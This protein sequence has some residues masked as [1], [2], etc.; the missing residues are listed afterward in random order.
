VGNRLA[1]VVRPVEAWA[2][3]RAEAVGDAVRVGEDAAVG[4]FSVLAI[5]VSKAGL[6]NVEVTA[7]TAVLPV[8]E[9]T[10]RLLSCRIS[11]LVPAVVTLSRLPE[12]TPW[13]VKTWKV[14]SDV[15]LNPSRL[16]STNCPP[17]CRLPVADTRSNEA[18]S[19]PASW[20]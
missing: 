2:V 14:W 3:L 17:N 16:L 13:L 11:R 5:S 7:G 18:V 6:V 4:V 9:A 12:T 20:I 10:T 8:V 15:G 1:A 19:D